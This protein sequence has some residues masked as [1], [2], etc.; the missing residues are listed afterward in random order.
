MMQIQLQC[1]IAMPQDCIRHDRGYTGGRATRRLEIYILIVNI[2][3]I[4]NGDYR[5]G[6]W[7][8]KGQICSPISWLG[9]RVNSYSAEFVVIK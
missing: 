1:L 7:Q 6:R 9:L 5:C 2:L 4:I 8:P 3:V